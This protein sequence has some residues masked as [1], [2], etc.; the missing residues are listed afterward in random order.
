MRIMEKIENPRTDNWGDKVPFFTSNF[1]SAFNY[2]RKWQAMW[3]AKSRIICLIRHPIDTTISNMKFNTK[4]NYKIERLMKYQ[5]L[6]VPKIVEAIRFNQEDI[7]AV[8]Y[9]SLVTRPYLILQK[10][11]KFCDLDYYTKVV[12]KVIINGLKSSK[13]G[14]IDSSRA[15]AYRYKELDN[16]TKLESLSYDYEGLR[17]L[18][19]VL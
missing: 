9:E 15:Y 16:L 18:E 6:V 11:Y 13:K 14:F 10:I 17:K 19:Y 3:G 7:L 5:T 4:H 8:S 1:V 2:L 12:N